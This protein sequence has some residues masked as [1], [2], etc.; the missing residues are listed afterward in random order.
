MRWILRGVSL[1][2]ILV[3]VAGVSIL[4]LPQERIARIATD[5]LTALTGREVVINGDVALTIWPVLG[6]RVEGLEVGGPAWAAQQPMISAEIA[7][8]GLDANSLIKGD[9]HIT[10][11]EADRPIIRLEQKT[12]GRASWLLTEPA[13]TTVSTPSNAYSDTSAPAAAA[14]A[15]EL[16]PDQTRELRIDNVRVTNATFIYDAEGSDVIR[17]D[18]VDLALDWPDPEGAGVVTARIRPAGSPVSVRAEVQKLAAFLGGAVQNV[19][20]EAG[21]AAGQLTFDG[22]ASVDGRLDGRTRFTARDTDAFLASLGLDPVDLPPGLGRS[23][24]MRTTLTLVPEG[25][26]A[27]R[28]LVVDLGGNI[29]RGAVDFDTE[30]VPV[31]RARLDAGALD[32]RAALSSDAAPVGTPHSTSETRPKPAP[33]S[34]S[35]ASKAD[36]GWPKDRIDASGLAAFNGDIALNA[37]SIDLGTLRLG[38]TRT[39]LRNDRSRMV[40]EL[41][42]VAAYGGT[43]TGDFVINNRNGLSVG[44]RLNAANLQMQPV[45]RDTIDFDRLTGAAALQFSF[46]G[47]GETVHDIM[48]SLSGEGRMS[49]GQG[50]IIGL[51]LDRLMRG[52]T[53]GGGTT[54]FDSLNA[55]WDID[56]GILRNEDLLLQLKN[57]EA[58][59]DG[60]VGLGSQTLDYT[61][62][63]VALRAN[64]G[65]GLAIPIRLRGPW[66]DISILPDLDAALDARIDDEV[67]R[68]E[69]KAKQKADEEVKRLEEKAKREVDDKIDE[70][71]RDAETSL[72]DEVKDRLLR[73]LFD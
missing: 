64:S 71:V 8:I 43:V 14:P 68:L 6:V 50:T 60:Q 20:L 16:T 70:I 69:E 32:L 1:I 54:I 17:Y 49:I 38:P 39:V 55:T 11:V 46:L 53:T 29:V 37:T 41:V 63:P 48:N 36:S 67:E 42:D 22:R 56:R 73:K 57:Y 66:S 72:E 61:F 35:S 10:H 45:L 31:V 62:T 34:Q 44:G 12:D 21:L 3:L 51:D 52:D 24:D 30:Y 18:T 26:L 33:R 19:S 2:L 47:V 23:I 15:Q 28:D 25:R 27:L 5:Q 59:G 9:I 58:R 4:F 40:F 65:R 7:A 13:A